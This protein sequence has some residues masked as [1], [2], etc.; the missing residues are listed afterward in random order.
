MLPPAMGRDR[1]EITEDVVR[2]FRTGDPDAAVTVYRTLSGPVYGYLL[3]RMGDP[4]G[5]QDVTGDAFTEAL[6]GASGF[7]GPPRGLKAWIFQIAR[8]RMVD[9]F[10]RE[11]YRRHPSIDELAAAGQDPA[12]GDDPESEALGHV[13]RERILALTGELT[14]DQREVILL[15]LVGDLS[16]ADTAELMERSPGAVKVLLHRALR[17]LAERIE[18]V[19]DEPER[20][21]PRGPSS[22]PDNGSEQDEP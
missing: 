18:V 15:R 3:Q 22:A 13:E 19:D 4:E 8:N 6:E 11:S 10:R 7:E 12:A 9:H 21:N 20:R 14:P 1:E 5:A 16:V 2:G 17:A